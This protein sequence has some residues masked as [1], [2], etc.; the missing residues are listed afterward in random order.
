MMI[1]PKVIFS[2]SAPVHARAS[3]PQVDFVDMIGINIG[4]GQSPSM[5]DIDLFVDINP[6]AVRMVVENCQY[7]LS[8]RCFRIILEKE[9]ARVQSGTYYAVTLQPGSVS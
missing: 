5:S 4:G 9:N 8:L 6:G 1:S 7:E 2:S 3:N